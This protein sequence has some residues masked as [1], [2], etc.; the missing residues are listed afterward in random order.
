MT[1][2][3]TSPRETRK[4]PIQK[5]WRDSRE[6]VVAIA[7]VIAAIAAIVGLVIAYEQLHD[8]SASQAA[9]R[10]AKRTTEIRAQA[11]AISGAVVSGEHGAAVEE[12]PHGGGYTS[13]ALYNHSATPVYDVVVSLVFVRGAGPRTGRELK[14]LITGL[15][16]YV[17]TLPPGASEVRVSPGWAGMMAVP[18]V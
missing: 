17:S 15:Q 7:A 14:A 1:E 3:P 11:E 13:I 6:N 16:R 2:T 5:L 12:D 8:Q 18:G 9:D 10:V 4:S